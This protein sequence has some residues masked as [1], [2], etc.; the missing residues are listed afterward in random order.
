MK[1]KKKMTKI[2]QMIKIKLKNKLPPNLHFAS[3]CPKRPDLLIL[4]AE[5]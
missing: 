2:K 4:A 1:V 3:Y 5:M